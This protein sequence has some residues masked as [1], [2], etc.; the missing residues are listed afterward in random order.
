MFSFH[1]F[2]PPV[3]AALLEMEDTP[4]RCEALVWKPE[5]LQQKG[6]H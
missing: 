5:R 3:K 1:S 4:S 2:C 6:Q